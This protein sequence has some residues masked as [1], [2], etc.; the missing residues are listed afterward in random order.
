MHQ[1]FKPWQVLQAIDDSVTGGLNYKGIDTFRDAIRR[2][3]PDEDA[4]DN[5]FVG[6]AS[7]GHRKKRK[8]SVPSSSSVKRCSYVLEKHAK[9]NYIDFSTSIID[10]HEVVQFNCVQQV[11][12]RS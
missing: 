3:F 6:R 8:S 5:D 4:E 11:G 9:E 12:K 10:G 1:I 7:V 2:S